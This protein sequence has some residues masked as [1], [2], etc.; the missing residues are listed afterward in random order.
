MNDNT[1]N[2][3]NNEDNDK[4]DNKIV[5]MVETKLKD[6]PNI[7]NV[8]NRENGFNTSGEVLKRTSKIKYIPHKLDIQSSLQ[9]TVRNLGI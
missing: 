1:D 5:N 4:G 7:K 2:N 8:F 9:Q 3:D 6:G